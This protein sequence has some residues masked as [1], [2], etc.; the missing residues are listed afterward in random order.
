MNETFIELEKLAEERGL[1][2]KAYY[3]ICLMDGN[4]LLLTF[5][6]ELSMLNYLKEHPEYHK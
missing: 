1:R 2:I 5:R 3:Q 4:R 6:D